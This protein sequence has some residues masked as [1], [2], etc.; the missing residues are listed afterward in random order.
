MPQML[1]ELYY[2][3]HVVR[4]K[5]P[6]DRLIRPVILVMTALNFVLFALL[7]NLYFFVP[8]VLFGLLMLWYFRESRK[9]FDYILNKGELEAAVIL[10]GNSRRTLFCVDVR[11]QLV[12]MAPSRTEPVQPWIGK[13]MKTWDC[14]SHTGAPYYCMIMQDEGRK[15][16]KA[17]FEP[18]ETLLGLLMQINPGKVHRQA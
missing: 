14:T 8:F 1:Q 4:A 18:D 11:E 5:P 16:Y 6:M 17:L 12:V 7:V 13:K 9:E 15:E 2:E 10:G 3:Q